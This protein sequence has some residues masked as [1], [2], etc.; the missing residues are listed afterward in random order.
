[1]TASPYRV[2]ALQYI[3]GRCYSPVTF[4][5][6]FYIMP[7]YTAGHCEVVQAMYSILLD[8]SKAV[9]YVGIKPATFRLQPSSQT[10]ILIVILENSQL[11]ILEKKKKLIGKL[12]SKALNPK[13]APRTLP[14]YLLYPPL[15]SVLSGISRRTSLT[16]RNVFSMDLP[17]LNTG[18]KKVNENVSLT[19]RVTH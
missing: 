15:G 4:T 14:L 17:W 11:V 1:M 6:Q 8:V 16:K 9:F 5:T 3:T 10:I 18:S 7:M 19:T 12:L 2:H 13:T